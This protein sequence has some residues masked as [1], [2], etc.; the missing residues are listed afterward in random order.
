MTRSFELL[1]IAII[2][3]ISIVSA[4]QNSQESGAGTS[5][6]S[7]NEGQTYGKS[8]PIPKDW[9]KAFNS[10]SFN[11][12]DYVS[13]YNKNR[14]GYRTIS[15]DEL[16][17]VKPAYKWLCAL[18]NG[19]LLETKISR[20]LP[21]EGGPKVSCNASITGICPPTPQ[22]VSPCNEYVYSY[23]CE[24][25]TEGYKEEKIKQ[26]IVLQKGLSEL[27]SINGS[28]KKIEKTYNNVPTVIY[29][30]ETNKHG[31]FL[32]IFKITLKM[33]V[34][35]DPDTGEVIDKHKPW[36]AFLV[37]GEEKYDSEAI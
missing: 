36:W 5:G 21:G 27:K 20:C 24:N 33:G 37:S 28:I 29:N 22:E 4:Y 6:I 14:V 34:E 11:E 32:G 15:S 31:K 19:T 23:S 25:I 3:L 17:M 30:I 26:K 2:G 7:Y 12:E 1:I 9:E 16:E 13:A 18:R 10:E 8:L 35:V